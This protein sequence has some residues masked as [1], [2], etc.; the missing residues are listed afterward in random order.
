M[1][2]Y[3]DEEAMTCKPCNAARRIFK[4]TDKSEGIRFE[5]FTRWIENYK[6]DFAVNS[7]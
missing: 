1:N 7:P 5:L 6:L 3:T 2:N 4:K